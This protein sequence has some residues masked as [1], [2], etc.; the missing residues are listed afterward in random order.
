MTRGW[1]ARRHAASWPL[2]GGTQ[3]PWTPSVTQSRFHYYK[4]KRI[5]IQWHGHTALVH[6]I[7]KAMRGWLTPRSPGF[8]CQGRS[9]AGWVHLTSSSAPHQI[10]AFWEVKYLPRWD[11]SQWLLDPEAKPSVSRNEINASTKHRQSQRS[12]FF[13]GI[14]TKGNLKKR[15]SQLT[16]K[17][18]MTPQRQSFSPSP[19][20]KRF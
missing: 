5:N 18:K 19:S 6:P 3:T 10:T 15:P 4:K 9:C 1:H 8:W 7:G 11:I 13:V 2:S 14:C 20:F 17:L 16:D 12:T